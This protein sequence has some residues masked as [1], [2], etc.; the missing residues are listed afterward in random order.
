MF[1]Q[2]NC[3][4]LILEKFPEFLPHW[5][6][7]LKERRTLDRIDEELS[8]F[9]SE[10]AYQPWEIEEML[11]SRKLNFYNTLSQ[12]FSQIGYAQAEI[13]RIL[14]YKPTEF[15]F[16]GDMAAFSRY[17]SDLLS[18]KKTAPDYLESIFSFIETL[19]K[20]GDEDVQNAVCT[21]FLENILNVFPEIFFRGVE[22]T[23]FRD[24]YLYPIFWTQATT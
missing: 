2:K 18:D 23:K 1:S 19:L 12:F 7:H 21:C 10:H 20:E 4:P 3:L 13:E 5:K 9:I 17:V 8:Q 6:N 16:W 22:S 14:A 24:A 11:S 15:D